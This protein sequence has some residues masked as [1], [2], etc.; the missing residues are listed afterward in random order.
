MNYLY[1]KMSEQ[2]KPIVSN[3][4]VTDIRDDINRAYHMVSFD[5][6]GIYTKNIAK[7]NY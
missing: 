7:K 1:T 6:N 3:A 2:N 5:E 4:L